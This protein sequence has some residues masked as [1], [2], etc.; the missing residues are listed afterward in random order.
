M[1]N[2]L[3]SKQRF[4]YLLI[5]IGVVLFLVYILAIKKTI[6][7]KAK[8]IDMEAIHEKAIAE[9][10]NKAMLEYQ[11]MK[12]Q[13]SL[14]AYADSSGKAQDKLLKT[15]SSFTSTKTVMLKSYEPPK[16]NGEINTTVLY[17]QG[18]YINLLKVSNKLENTDGL[19]RVVHTLF[20]TSMD[21]NTRKKILT[22]KIIVQTVI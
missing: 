18:N 11:L 22:L 10:Q 1:F 19:G 12:I 7:V 16:T 15:I 3:S 5:G 20:E 6:D 4:N 2:N 21:Y 8:A 13:K 17:L 14:A 9:P